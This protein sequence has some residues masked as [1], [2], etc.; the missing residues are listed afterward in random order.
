MSI[1]IR[2]N[3]MVLLPVPANRIGRGEYGK[4]VLVQF[5]SRGGGE[6]AQARKVPFPFQVHQPVGSLVVLGGECFKEMVTNRLIA[7][8]D[9]A[10]H[11]L[12]RSHVIAFPSEIFDRVNGRVTRSGGAAGR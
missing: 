2:G 1:V 5:L 11:A 6:P 3:R 4:E 12:P 7:V 10:A 8:F 9:E